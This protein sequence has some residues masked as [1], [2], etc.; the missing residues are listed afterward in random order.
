MVLTGGMGPR[1]QALFQQNRINVVVG[2]MESDPEKAVLR[3]LQGNL[4]VGDNVCDH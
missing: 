3:Y 4:E 2:V 1:A